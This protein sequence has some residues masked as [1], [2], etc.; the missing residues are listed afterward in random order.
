MTTRPSEHEKELTITVPVEVVVKEY[1]TAFKNI[2]QVASRPGFRPGKL[3]A[4][5]VKQFYGS[6]I[7]RKL[8]DKLVEKSF[9]ET[10]QEKNLT[11]VS[12]AK[13]EIVGEFHP[14]RDLTFRAIF[15]AKPQV[16]INKFEGLELEFKNII[17]HEDDLNEELKGVRESHALFVTPP[18]RDAI[19]ESDLVECDS[20]VFIDGAINANY[21]HKDYSVPLFAENIPADL[22][23]ALV[24]KKIGEIAIV[25]YTMPDD[26]QDEAI[27]GKVCEMRLHIKAFKERVLPELNDDFAKDLSEKFTNLEDL[28]ESIKLRLTISANRR[29][30]YYNQNAL[31][32]ALV[33]NNP[34]EIPPAMVERAALTLINRE[35]ENMDKAMAKEALA[36][37]WQELWNSVQARALFKV[38]TDLI[39][40]ALIEKLNINAQE[41]EIDNRV[42]N[43]KDLAR[44]DAKYSIQVDKLLE[45]LKKSAHITTVEE[46]LYPKGN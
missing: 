38:K 44:E 26:H 11:P 18:M 41:E 15:Q 40:E 36:N 12:P 46:P 6:E 42:H 2:Q 25:H 21:S 27:K 23:S 9:A 22:K 45:A 28:K 16:I 19:A 1:A 33:E 32:K 37:H 29:R 8:I 7:N 34:V 24:G 10:C 17:V 14:E 43:T 3:P 5:L 39:L 30:D 31:I 13:T 35:I 20:D 4:N